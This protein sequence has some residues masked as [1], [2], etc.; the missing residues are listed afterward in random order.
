MFEKKREERI[1]KLREQ[2]AAMQQA[3]DTQK[4]IM[5]RYLEGD[6]DNWDMIKNELDEHE[7]ATKHLFPPKNPAVVILA[8]KIKTVDEALLVIKT[9][10]QKAERLHDVSLADQAKE[11]ER[12]IKFGRPDIHTYYESPE[13]A[14]LMRNS[15]AFRCAMDDLDR[16]ILETK[17]LFDVT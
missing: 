15:E 1:A 13:F 12:L 3:V 9:Y 2:R 17:H 5:A 11:K 4:A 7:T 16:I 8:K 6:G 14:H 10:T